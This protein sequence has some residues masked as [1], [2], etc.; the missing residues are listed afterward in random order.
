M[1]EESVLKFEKSLT[2]IE[3]QLIKKE[4][5][6]LKSKKVNKEDPPIVE[7]KRVRL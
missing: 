2:K 6:K 4:I 5:G 3:S 1:A 7:K